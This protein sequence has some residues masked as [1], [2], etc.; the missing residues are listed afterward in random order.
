M[1]Y[2]VSVQGGEFVSVEEIQE[3]PI[4]PIL[5]AKPIRD[6]ECDLLLLDHNDIDNLGLTCRWLEHEKQQFRSKAN[7]IDLVLNRFLTVGEIGGF[8]DIQVLTGMVVSGSVALQF[9][10][11][12]VY[13]TDLDTYCV[14][15]KCLDVAKYYQSI[16]YEYRPSKD[17]LDHFEDD[18]S[19]IVDW[20]WYTENRGPYLQDNVL[21]VWN[22]DRNGSKIQL[23]ATAR[24]PLEAI[25][26]FHSTCVMN[27]ITHR[28]AYCL[29]A[30]TTFKERC[31]VV[32]DR[33]DRYNATGVEKY[34]ARGFESDLT[35]V[36]ARYMKD[37]Q[38]W[39]VAVENFG[40]ES[41]THNFMEGNSFEM[42]YS[43][44]KT[45]IMYVPVEEDTYSNLIA[46]PGNLRHLRKQYRRTEDILA[47]NFIPFDSSFMII[48][49][50]NPSR[51]AGFVWSEHAMRIV[52]Q[53]VKCCDDHGVGRVFAPWA[54][55]E[56]F[57]FIT[58]LT[59]SYP[60]AIVDDPY[61]YR[62]KDEVHLKLV[63]KVDY[64]NKKKLD[65]CRFNEWVEFLSNE[66]ILILFTWDY[67]T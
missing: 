65:I 62:S 55:Y 6:T 7:K 51:K 25:L 35:G 19:R 61:L 11:R 27:V 45:G 15:G 16:R 67:S 54:F 64:P 38:T 50:L 30:R 41:A 33:G 23:I 40:S 37:Y 46:A 36:A 47:E 34:R 1:A 49:R 26:K 8:Q 60:R 66:G 4:Q 24:S 17:Q 13:R 56:L 32:I 39:H 52:C 9:F 21:Q 63:I 18:L 5:S 12:E 28:R 14:L 3:K 57:H 48:Q 58:S 43:E 2:H 29:F 44:G 42:G 31:T 59:H 53:V 20:R 22:F 10:S